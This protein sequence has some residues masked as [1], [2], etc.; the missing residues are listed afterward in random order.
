MS[1]NQ[2]R[3]AVHDEFQNASLFGSI[4]HVV[5]VESTSMKLFKLLYYDFKHTK[6]ENYV[7][8]FLDQGL[9]LFTKKGVLF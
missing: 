9:S 7:T 5:S 3:T 1:N 8:Q 6:L 2:Q 4:L